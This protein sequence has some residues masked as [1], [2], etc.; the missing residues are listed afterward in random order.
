MSAAGLVPLGLALRLMATPAKPEEG[1]VCSKNQVAFRD[2]CYEFVPFGRSFYG[3]QNWCEERGGHLVFIHDEGTQRFLQKHISQ[4]REWWIGLTGNSAQNGTAEGPGIWLD[5]SNV[6]YSHWHGR[7][8]SPAP[9]T[10]GY[11]GR[12][13]SARWAA[14][15]NCAQLFTFI[16]EFGVGQSLACEGHDAT[17][18][19]G[20]G[21]V[22]Q[23]RDAFYRRQ[24][25][26][27]CTQDAGSPLDLEEKCSWVSVKGKVAG[28]QLTVSNESF[29]FDNVT[30]SLMW[31]LSPYTGNLSLY[32]YHGGW[33]HF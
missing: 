32:H 12:D 3:A 6:N 4:D 11:I 2:S 24:T 15:D 9:D 23:I 26:H 10:C 28:L 33:P 7:Q 1:S 20:S 29:V 13:P 22:I 17:M 14:S 19:C 25:T 16:C 18:H 30:I 8:A 5:T 31:L 27:Y 21:E